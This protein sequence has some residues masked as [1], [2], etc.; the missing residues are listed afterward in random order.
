LKERPLKEIS[1]NSL[2]GKRV[3]QNLFYRAYG[4]KEKLIMG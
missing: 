3:E 4:R 1:I 2:R